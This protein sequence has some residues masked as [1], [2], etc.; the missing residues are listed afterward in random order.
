[1]T[2]IGNEVHVL[3]SFNNPLFDVRSHRRAFLNYF[4]QILVLLNLIVNEQLNV[5]SMSFDVY[6]LETFELFSYAIKGAGSD[7][8]LSR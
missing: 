8:D 5:G 7:H 4:P 2:E 3:R 6:E 1:M